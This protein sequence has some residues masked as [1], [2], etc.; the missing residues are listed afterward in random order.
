M[1]LNE[2]GDIVFD[3]VLVLL[4]FVIFVFVLVDVWL[5]VLMVVIVECVGL[6]GLF[7]G[8]MCC[9]DGLFGKSDWV[10]VFGVFVLWIGFGLLVGSVVVWLWWLL[11]VLLIVMVVWCV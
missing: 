11:I 6:I 5:F 4:F 3:V 7:V 2:L 10:L 9:Y 8:V 1:Y